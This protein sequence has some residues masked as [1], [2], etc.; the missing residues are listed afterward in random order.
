MPLTRNE[1]DI[2]LLSDAGINQ[3]AIARDVGVSF[4]YVQ[5][6]VSRYGVNTY[7]ERRKRNLL[8]QQTRDLGRAVIAA[9]GHR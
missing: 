6:V 2:L 9:G 4:G 1:S 8:R 5:T 7:E 3:R